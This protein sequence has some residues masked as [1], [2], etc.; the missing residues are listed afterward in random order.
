MK[1]IVNG[2]WIHNIVNTYFMLLLTQFLVELKS[3]RSKKRFM[4]IIKVEKYL[5]IPKSTHISKNH[6]RN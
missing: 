2:I 3:T 5:M 6:I 4:F 1:E